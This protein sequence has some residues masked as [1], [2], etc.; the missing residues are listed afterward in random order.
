MEI[1]KVPAA[2]IKAERERRGWTQYQLARRSGIPEG[3]VKNLEQSATWLRPDN[4]ERLAKALGVPPSLFFAD[5]DASELRIAIRDLSIEE[6]V[7]ILG[8]KLGLEVTKRRQSKDHRP[9]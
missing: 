4:A 3:T 5:P 2:R 8:D 6:L 9:R 1:E 7:S